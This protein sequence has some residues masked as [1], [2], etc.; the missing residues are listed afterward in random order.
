M[1]NV[2]LPGLPDV[3]SETINKDAELRAL[4]EAIKITLNILTGADPKSND[5]LINY[6]N[7]NQ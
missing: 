4:L 2:N 5:S 6:I 7:S 1:A 3:Q